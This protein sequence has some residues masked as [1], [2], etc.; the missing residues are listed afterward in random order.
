MSSGRRPTP[1]AY[2]SS[3]IPPLQCRELAS[4]TVTVTVNSRRKPHV[5]SVKSRLRGR[6]GPERGVD[7][8]EV[9]STRSPPRDLVDAITFQRG[10]VM[11]RQENHWLVDRKPEA[12]YRRRPQAD[13]R[14]QFARVSRHESC[15]Q[16]RDRADQGEDVLLESSRAWW[17][18]RKAVTSPRSGAHRNPSCLLACLPALKSRHRV[19]ACSPPCYFLLQV[20]I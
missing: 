15:R 3:D 4:V 17:W 2:L 6:Q 14:V 20:T 12:R 7:P 1:V 11:C 10:H 19:P 18:S 8:R 13:L 9:C 5:A 16:P